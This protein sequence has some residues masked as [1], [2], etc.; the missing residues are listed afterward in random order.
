MLS[1]RF[2]RGFPSTGGCSFTLWGVTH[3]C[4]TQKEVLAGFSAPLPSAIPASSD[5]CRRKFPVGH[6]NISPETRAKSA[7][8]RGTAPR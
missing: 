8:D 5:G 4:E 2:R 6:A 3:S 7:E 1:D